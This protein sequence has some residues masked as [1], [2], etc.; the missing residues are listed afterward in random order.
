MNNKTVL[1]F[2]KFQKI[3][4]L[5]CSLCAFFASSAVKFSYLSF[6]TNWHSN[7]Y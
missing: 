1:E 3:I 5:L 4:M 7:D 6:N 2:K